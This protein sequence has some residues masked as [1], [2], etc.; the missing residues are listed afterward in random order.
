MSLILL[1][2]ILREF[3]ILMKVFY[4][5]IIIYF[6]G[7][8]FKIT[9]YLYSL[10]GLCL[11]DNVSINDFGISVSYVFYFFSLYLNSGKLLTKHFHESRGSKEEYIIFKSLD[12]K[13]LYIKETNLVI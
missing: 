11:L 13:F 5:L 1:H 9:D 3:I 12:V 7:L 10:F 8:R 2:S 4:N 6:F